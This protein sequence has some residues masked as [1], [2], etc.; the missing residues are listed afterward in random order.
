MKTMIAAIAL[1]TTLMAGNAMA[2]GYS[3]PLNP[4]YYISEN[5]TALSTPAEAGIASARLQLACDP[6]YYD[7]TCEPTTDNAK[8][9]ASNNG[10][11]LVLQPNPEYY[12]M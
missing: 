4:E 2:E 11:H 10:S 1:C 5:D 7:S 9:V 12:G 3:L 6:E 8:P